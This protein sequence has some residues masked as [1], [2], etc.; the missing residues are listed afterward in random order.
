M[1]LR[2][3]D[4]TSQMVPDAMHTIADFIEKITYLMIGKNLACNLTMGQ[5]N[6]QPPVPLPIHETH[7]LIRDRGVLI[8]HSN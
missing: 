2:F 4:R 7:H 1:R 3:H 5:K 6:P 8:F